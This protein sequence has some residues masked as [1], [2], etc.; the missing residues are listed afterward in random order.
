MHL[1][2]T[3]IDGLRALFRKQRAEHEMNEELRGYM[4]AAVNGK[5]R[6]GMSREDAL[7]AA[8]VEVGS[9][10]A[11]KEAIRSAGWERAVETV[12]Q[13]LRYAFRM[14][15]KSP[16]FTVVAIS[17]LAL[18]IGANTAIFSVINAVLLNP[19]PY[20]NANRL[21][22]VWEQ[23][24]ERGWFRNVV[25]AANFVDW[26]KQNHVFTQMAA[27]DDPSY[28]VSGTGEPTELQGEQV[29]A[30]FFS[31]LG[32]RAALGRTFTPD[33]DQPKSSRVVVL[34][35]ELWQQ[36]YGG[37]P[38]L[39]GETIRL[40]R[41][42][43]TVIGVMPRGFYFPPF[44]DRAQLWTAGLDLTKPARTAHEYTSVARLKPGISLERA[45]AEMD[46]IAS[47]L[48]QEYP[49][50]KGWGVQL[51]G[52]H[53]E[54]VGNTRPAL[55]V[56]LGAVGLVLLIACANLA[57]LQLV[58]IAGREKEIALRTALGA[59]RSRVI[60]QLLSESLLLAIAGGVGGLLL[61]AWGVKLLIM[62]APPDTPGLVHAGVN[63]ELLAFTLAISLAT[64]IAFGLVPA[65]G[66]LKVDLSKSLKEGGRGS[67]EGI[68]SHRAR[69]LLV[70]LEFAVALVL[71]AGAGLLI[72]SF[73][74]LNQIDLGFDP[75]NVLTMRIALLGPH[76]QERSAQVEFFRDLLRNVQPLSG[77]KSAA[78]ID[79]CDLPPDGGC[80]MSFVI[81][82]RPTPPPN[83]LPDASSRVI[84]S[85][86]FRTMGIALLR[87]RYFTDADNEHARRVVIINEKLARDYW[88]GRD[89]IGGRLDFTGLGVKQPTWFTI[90]GVVKSV[91][92]DGL[93]VA[94][95]DEVYVPYTQYPTWFTPRALVVRTS[96]D[97]ALLVAAVRHVVA[98][99]DK[100]QPISDVQTMDQIMSHA[101]AGHRFPMVLLGVFAALA[102][103]L[104]AIGI[105]GVVSYGV[106]QR[107]H[108]IGIR[109]AL[110][111]Q[112]EDVHRL[113]VG[114]GIR[115]GVTGIGLG[116]VVALGLTRLMATMLYG[117]KSSDPFTFLV[118]CLVLL[119]VAAFAC[120][121][122]ARRATKIDPMVAVRDE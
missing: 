99:L 112:K 37:N 110:G 20:R 96:D 121:I 106:S 30:D 33:E 95:R 89:P 47:R 49:E 26:R 58:R 75:H 122:P 116:I 79:G 1:L 113:V 34:S 43:Y 118:V 115:L 46:T 102:L 93:E 69:A 15:R 81:E 38:A 62:L 48:G 119:A 105:Y 12:W 97:P 11:V 51:I 23:N 13:D 101:E 57:N 77:V 4:D 25:S 117:V 5:M 22:M 94:P 72:R 111:A 29:S 66:A 67:T 65:L 70:S 8:R 21:M 28:D 19:L 40:N 56:L 78:V 107:T 50:Q 54:A 18:G 35:D 83:L 24:S 73:V 100:D 86:Y 59:G 88:P 17:T 52:V 3:L 2:R 114:Q 80:G 42:P 44:G 64:G 92:N 63:L 27:I 53:E 55:L 85:D 103:T 39:V 120:Y 76:Y 45:Q 84:S 10:E 68:R 7:R 74:A 36:R 41:I 60:R 31:V 14:L 91:K 90:A 16:G 108:E 104:A 87:G 32:V 82:G 109:M 98:A 6:S 61:A 71:L 9:M